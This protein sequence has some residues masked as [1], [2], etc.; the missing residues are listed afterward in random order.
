MEAEGRDRGRRRSAFE[1]LTDFV[2]IAVTNRNET[3]ND[4]RG[5]RRLIHRAEQNEHLR[6]ERGVAVE[7]DRVP[8]GVEVDFAGARF[9]LGGRLTL[10][11]AIG[12]DLRRVGR[13]GVEFL[14]AFAEETNQRFLEFGRF[15]VLRRVNVGGGAGN[16]GRGETRRRG[17]TAER[18]ASD[19]DAGRLGRSDA[20]DRAQNAGRDARVRLIRRERRR[21]NVERRE[22]FL[23]GAL[24]FAVRVNDDRAELAVDAERD[25]RNRRKF[26]ARERFDFVDLRRKA[27][28]RN[29]FERGVFARSVDRRFSGAREGRRERRRV[30]VGDFGTENDR[31]VLRRQDRGVGV[32]SDANEVVA[33]RVVVRFVRIAAGAAFVG[34]GRRDALRRV[35]AFDETGGRDKLIASG[36]VRVVIV[37]IELLQEIVDDVNRRFGAVNGD[38]VRFFVV[39]PKRLASQRIREKAAE[40]T[41]EERRVGFVRRRERLLNAAPVFRR[42]IRAV[43][44]GRRRRFRRF[45][46]ASV[47]GARFARSGRR[48][49]FRIG[50]RRAILRSKIGV[51]EREETAERDR[52]RRRAQNGERSS[53]RAFVRVAT[54]PR[55]SPEK[56]SHLLLF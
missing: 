14:E 51:R 8:F 26:A 24:E 16:G 49:R 37:A 20:V 2:R 50:R 45:R 7:R 48:N 25:L 9:R 15:A 52:E 1:D 44:R 54:R 53:R 13:V 40:V 39:A 36:D 5:R 27:T 10:N 55:V 6:A 12:R 4:A 41:A 31:F 22:V 23:D 30:F 11:E 21:V 29:D 17:R 43:G 56:L 46:G 34:G 3:A 38:F 32:V 18:L 42:E 35:F 33:F 47:S 19:A 28:V